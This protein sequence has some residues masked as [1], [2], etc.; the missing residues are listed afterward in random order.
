MSR[1]AWTDIVAWACVVIACAALAYGIVTGLMQASPFCDQ[2]AAC[3]HYVDDPAHEARFGFG[4]NGEPYC[5]I[6]EDGEVVAVLRPF[7]PNVLHRLTPE[8][9][10]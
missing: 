7:R 2:Q 9:L 5:A 8:D 6:H 10:E 1:Q 3:E 4:P